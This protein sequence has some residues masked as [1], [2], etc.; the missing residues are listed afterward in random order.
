MERSKK[1]IEAEIASAR[2]EEG[3]IVVNGSPLTLELVD[4]VMGSLIA[5]AKKEAEMISAVV[6]AATGEAR[7]V[8]LDMLP[9]IPGTDQ[10]TTTATFRDATFRLMLIE[11]IMEALSK[12]ES[13]PLEIRRAITSYHEDCREDGV[14]P[15]AT[16]ENMLRHLDVLKLMQAIAVRL[17]ELMATPV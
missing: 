6:Q 17:D 7:D 1:Y 11:G 13:V 15:R 4:M 12:R 8:M 3:M 9:R 16:A 14:H 2:F 5:D 10:E